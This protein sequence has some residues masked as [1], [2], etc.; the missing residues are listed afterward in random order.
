MKNSTLYRL[1]SLL[2]G[3]ALC[4]ALLSAS[5][6]Q[7]VPRGGLHG[8]VTMTEN[9][10]HLPKAWVSVELLG[11]ESPDEFNSLPGNSE[12]QPIVRHERTMHRYRSDKDGEISASNLPAGTYIVEVNARAHSSKRRAITIEEGKSLD[13]TAMI[14]VDPKD[15]ELELYASQRVFTPDDKPSFEI[16]GFDP[17]AQ[18][19]IHYY[20]LDLGKIVSKGGLSTLLYSFSRP[21]NEGGSDPSKS[22]VSQDKFDK[23]LLSKDIEGVFVEP[24]T[25]PK[26]D[27]GFYYVTCEVGKQ[28]RATYL[29][30]STIGLVTKTTKNDALC[31]VTDLVTG[32]PVAGASIEQPGGS[33]LK[34]VATTDKSGLARVAVPSSSAKKALLFA[35]YGQSQA[36]VDFDNETNENGQGSR[37]FMYSDRPIYRP[38]DTV[39]FKGIV[40]KLQDLKYSLPPS[41]QVSIE[42]LDSDDTRIQKFSL[43]LSA[44]GTFNGT[45][46]TNVEDKPGSYSIHASY[47]G[48]SYTYYVNI[49][50]YRKPEFSIKVTSNKKF[51]VYGDKASATVKAEYYFG[52]PVVGA[53][54]EAYVTRRPN[55]YY[56]GDYGA[57]EG[58]S[59]EGGYSGGYYAKEFQGEYDE[60]VE[61]VTNE[62]GEAVIEFNTKTDGDPDIPDYDLDYSV[63]ASITDASNKFFDGSGDV[64][65]MRGDVSADLETDEYIT[66]PGSTMNAKVVVKGQEDQKPIANKTVTLEV[67]TETWEDTK[68]EFTL[69]QTL[70]GVTDSKG[71][72]TIPFK[73][74]DEGS[75]VLKS[76]VAD[77][78]GRPVKSVA[79]VYVEGDRLF[80][81][82]AESFTVTLDK[83]SYK[84]GDRCRV[85]VQTNKPGGSAL[86]TVQ[87]EKVLATYVVDLPK[88]STV[89]TIPVTRDYTPNVWV[90]AIAVR[91]KHLLEAQSRLTVDT[92]EH[93][94]KISVTPDK[95]DYLPGDTAN[96]TIK[97]MNADG[98]PVSADVSLGIVDESIYAIQEDTTNIKR[99]FYPMRSDSVRTNYSFEE[100]YLDGGDKGGGNIPVRTKFLDTASW[101][102][103]IETDASGTA[104]TSIKL[105]DNLTSWRATAIGVT[106]ATQVGLT[107]VN[108]RAR[109]PLSVRLELPSF[110]VQQDTQKITAIITNDTGQDREVNVRLEAQGIGVSGQMTQKVVVTAAKPL[111]L[112]WDV[113]TQNSGT[114]KLTAYVWTDVGGFQDAEGRDLTVEPHGRQLLEVHSGDIQG[115]AE[116]TFNLSPHADP[117]SGRLQL[118]ISPSIGTMIYQSLDELIDFPYGCT[119]QTMSRFLPTVVLSSTLKELNMRADLEAKVP[120][121]V[122]DGFARLAKMQ[123]SNGA[124]GWWEYD[125]ASLYMT[126]YVL[127]GLH[128]AKDAGFESTRID[129][130]KAIEWAKKELNDAKL[131]NYN[132]GDFLYL[133]YATS[134]YGAHDEVREALKRVKATSGPDY[135]LLALTQHQLG[136]AAA[137]GEALAKLHGAM[138]VEGD[139]ARFKSLW[140]YG[141]TST[142]F[143]LI[144]LTTLTPQDPFI[145]KI[146]RGLALDR[147]GDMWNSTR[148]SALVLIGLTQHMKST[149]DLGK[150]VDLDIVVNGGTPRTFHFDP[151]NQF[152]SVL[153]VTIPVSE[154]KPGTNKVEFRRTGPEGLCYY[155]AELKQIELADK[156]LPIQTNSG[157]TV[158]RNYYLLAPQRMESG[159]LELRP[160]K[161][162]TQDV[163]SGDLV[164]VELLISSDVDREYIMIED[165]I[166]SGCRITERE[167]VDENEEWTNWWAQTIVRDDRAAFFVRYMRK[168]VQKLTYT[169][170]AEQIGLGHALPTSVSNMYDPTQSASGGEN[171]LQ[172]SP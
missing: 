31:F 78:S 138:T 132:S 8:F 67:G 108:F 10:K 39:Q 164:R 123:H 87:A 23:A 42:I 133:C 104:H 27:Q 102:P 38:G 35:T 50:A 80:G 20:R 5:V 155:G 128:R 84:A 43:P 129:T 146:V 140:Y 148:D 159:S 9:G 109:K 57:D 135:A 19:T 142:A 169:V 90:S 103:D 120:G 18:A 44:K 56:G 99:G 1:L 126:A 2:L 98:A 52:G 115:T 111:A 157:L 107:H 11:G 15:P 124:W 106:G 46:A 118:T 60:Q 72:A 86:I 51:F 33:G 93:D 117:N 139:I 55:Y 69:K 112:T 167:Y 48:A 64:P 63:N 144:A 136:D 168:G 13:I 153:K 101:Q 82:P 3:V 97:T 163:K 83:R 113:T 95:P 172:V 152:N 53:K 134:L 92:T 88:E 70:T 125:D 156:L 7:E 114:A 47:G 149:R 62:K 30:I 170:R 4:V 131:D 68:S 165:P 158:S 17:S 119:E 59:E 37:I 145:T 77:S 22:A 54:V 127:D 154:L 61:A 110:L 122:A 130:E 91:N 24:I 162:A 71:I 32:R 58:D 40:R 45:Y 81:P 73:V 116:A 26:L 36:V 160:L 141:A 94:L 34:T 137:Q 147:R 14:A 75:V 74:S 66:D 105:P 171:L 41:G 85:M 16:H 151:A 96:V 161:Q 29:N 166:P 121:I 28:S 150:P 49:A 6:T 100:I 12:F 76:T 65:V 79:Y 25:L 143:P 89:V 21:G